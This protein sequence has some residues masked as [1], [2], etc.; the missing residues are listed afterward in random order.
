MNKRV[1]EGHLNAVAIVDV[2][3]PV[4]AV[5]AEVRIARDRRT[6]NNMDSETKAIHVRLEQWGAETHDG[7]MHGFP[8]ITMLGRL[9]EQG[10]MG[11]AQTG[12]P[13]V[14][15]SD[16]AA[17]VDACVSKLCY[18]DQRVLRLYYQHWMTVFELSRKMSMRER[19]AQNVL[20][21]ARWRL[22]AYLSVME[23]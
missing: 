10:P 21:R 17:C 15:L 4:H 19:Q 16:A 7:V 1:A 2:P 23:G 20:R 13:P 22:G 3:V 12:M 5:K 11:A 14:A 6:M 18:V 9:I 8:P